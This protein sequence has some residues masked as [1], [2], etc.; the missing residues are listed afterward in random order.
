MLILDS[1][2]LRFIL[3]TEGG[4]GYSNGA[5]LAPP[6][7]PTSEEAEAEAEAAPSK[8]AP[9][10]CL[11]GVA[12]RDSE[13]EAGFLLELNEPLRMPDAFFCRR[14][15]PLGRRIIVPVCAHA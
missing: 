2:L 15:R 6:A 12:S 8:L 9:L 7:P 4:I 1:L 10:R 14:R 11:E 5:S 3:R 13:G